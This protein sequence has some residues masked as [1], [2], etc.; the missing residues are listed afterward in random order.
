MFATCAIG[1]VH[2]GTGRH[3]E[4][5]SDESKLKAMRASTPPCYVSDYI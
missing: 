1:G 2:Y 5:L 3:M 4:D